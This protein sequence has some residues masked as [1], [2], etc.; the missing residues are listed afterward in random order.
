MNDIALGV[1]GT[2]A[3]VLG[4]GCGVGGKRNIENLHFTWLILV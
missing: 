4:D 1:L 3:Y 2:A